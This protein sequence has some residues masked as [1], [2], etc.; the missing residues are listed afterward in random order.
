ME[1]TSIELAE[2]QVTTEENESETKNDSPWKDIVKSIPS[3]N[4][5]SKDVAEE[6]KQLT[7]TEK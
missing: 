1:A 4:E 7:V 2:A 3:S 6:L 5:S